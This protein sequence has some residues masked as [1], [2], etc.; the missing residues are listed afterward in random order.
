MWTSTFDGRQAILGN[1]G[2]WYEQ[3]A[4]GDWLLNRK[5]RR[6]AGKIK[7]SGSN[8][9]LIHGARTSWDGNVARNDGSVNFETRPD[10]ENIPLFDWKNDGSTN[11]LPQRFDN[12]FA[13]EDEQSES[14][15]YNTSDDD[16]T[17]ATNTRRNNYLRCFGDRAARTLDTERKNLIAIGGFWYD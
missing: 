5:D 17:E 8:T 13:N 1:R 14:A 11:Q 4:A 9:L 3:D 6:G 15:R 10:P 12:V 16:I 2:P 7:A